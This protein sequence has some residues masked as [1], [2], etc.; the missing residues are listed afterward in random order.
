[1]EQRR[2]RNVIAIAVLEQLKAAPALSVKTAAAQLMQA[3]AERDAWFR[4]VAHE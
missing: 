2:P 4:A 3:I 1:M